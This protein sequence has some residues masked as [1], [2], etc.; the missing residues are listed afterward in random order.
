MM[1]IYRSSDQV[2]SWLGEKGDH[3]EVAPDFIT[4]AFMNDFL[5]EWMLKALASEETFMRNR[6]VHLLCC[7]QEQTRDYWRRLWVTQEIAVAQGGYLLIGDFEL[8]HFALQNVGKVFDFDLISHHDLLQ[9]CIDSGDGGTSAQAMRSLQ[10]SF[11]KNEV[12]TKVVQGTPLLDLLADSSWKSALDPRDKVFGLLGISDLCESAHPGLTIDYH[13]SIRE[14]YI[15]VMRAI[16]DITSNLDVLPFCGLIEEGSID[17]RNVPLWVLDWAKNEQQTL[18][19]KV[20]ANRAASDSPASVKLHPDNC[21]MSTIGFCVGKVK[22]CAARV[23]F[24]EDFNRDQQQRVLSDVLQ[25]VNQWRKLLRETLGSTSDLD[26]EYMGMILLGKPDQQNLRTFSNLVDEA[27][28]DPAFYRRSDWGPATLDA[29]LFII[30]KNLWE[31]VFC[32]IETNID[33]SPMKCAT[34]PH[35]GMGVSS[36]KQGDEICVFLGCGHPMVIR[37]HG[38]YYQ[39]VGPSY[40]HRLAGGE[41]M[42]DLEN[43]VHE[44]ESFDLR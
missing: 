6:F 7:L 20:K 33:K 32:L 19:K 25:T 43:G 22:D 12:V 30:S 13:Q 34:V 14:V 28:N 29:S 9:R 40:I 10:S 17:H 38:D 4:A 23:P 42:T 39:V 5:R 35:M 44:L 41:A 1:D 2:V 21:T 18:G 24:I 16:I 31:A 27:S 8:P 36:I 11:L 3:S 26:S 15:G 37:N